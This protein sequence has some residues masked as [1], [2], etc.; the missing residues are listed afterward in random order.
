[1]VAVAVSSATLVVSI[2]FAR[3]AF[4]AAAF[5]D[6]DAF[7]G[8]AFAT[9]FLASARLRMVVVF[10]F[11]DVDTVRFAMV[12]S[13]NRMRRKPPVSQDHVPR[14]GVSTEKHSSWSML[15]RA[16]AC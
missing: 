1:M 9:G 12:V 6:V 4:L 7:E 5:R 14:R 15:Q 13:L 3:A 16:R 8:L 2:A 10:L 11:F